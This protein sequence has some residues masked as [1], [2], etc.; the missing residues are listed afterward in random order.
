[1]LFLY[2]YFVFL[3]ACSL[4]LFLVRL[5]CFSAPKSPD[6]QKQRHAEQWSFLLLGIRLLIVDAL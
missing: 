2:F 6:I 4:V 1:M 3:Y 5:V